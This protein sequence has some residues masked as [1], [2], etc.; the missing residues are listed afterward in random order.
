MED[1]FLPRAYLDDTIESLLDIAFF[2]RIREMTPHPVTSL[3]LGIIWSIEVS[4]L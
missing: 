3:M 4:N 1:S 2:T